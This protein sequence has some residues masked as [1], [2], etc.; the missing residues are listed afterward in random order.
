MVAD[1]LEHSP[2]N[3]ES[4]SL[5]LV[6]MISEFLERHSKAKHTKAPAYSRALRRFHCVKTAHN[7]SAAIDAPSHGWVGF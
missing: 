5:S 1:W 2:C 7:C 4:T 6:I 3:A